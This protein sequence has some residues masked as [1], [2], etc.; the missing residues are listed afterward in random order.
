MI[1][2]GKKLLAYVLVLVMV[3]SLVPVTARAEEVVEPEV[4]E[5]H[6]TTET[7]G[8]GSIPYGAQAEL[9]SGIADVEIISYTWYQIVPDGEDELVGSDTS[10]YT[11]EEITTRTAYYC[12]MVD[13]DGAE[14]RIDFVVY[15]DSGLQAWV[16]GDEDHSDVGEISVKY[17]TPAE[18]TV[19]TSLSEEMS[20]QN[21]SYVWYKCVDDSDDVALD[22]SSASL[23][24]E[25]INYYTNYYCEVSDAYGN[26]VKVDFHISV[27]TGLYALTDEEEGSGSM[28]VFVIRGEDATLKVRAGLHYGPGEVHYEWLKVTGGSGDVISGANNASLELTNVTE[29]A[30]YHCKVSDDYGSHINVQ[31]DVYVDSGLE[32]CVA[33]GE[34]GEVY[35]YIYVPME[36]TTS[37]AVEASVADG[38]TLSYAWYDENPDDYSEG[39]E[40]YPTPLEDGNEDDTSYTTDAVTEQKVYYCKVRDEYGGSITLYFYVYIDSGLKAYV[41]DD[42]NQSDEAHINVVP[43]AAATLEVYATANEGET[44]TYEW[45]GETSG[46]SVLV[47]N[48]DETA[49]VYAKDGICTLKNINENAAYCCTVYD[50]YGN[51]KRIWFY[52]NVDTELTAYAKDDEFVRVPLNETATLEVEANVIEGVTLRYE[53]SYWNEDESVYEP[54][55]NVNGASCITKPITKREEYVCHV[56]DSCGNEA[57]VQ[58]YV[59]VDSNLNIEAVGDTTRTVSAGQT[60]QLAVKATADT[61]IT[62]QWNVFGSEGWEKVEGA[63]SDAY[64]VEDVKEATTYI[65]EVTDIYGDSVSQSFRIQVDN[66]LVATAKDNITEIKVDKNGSAILQ[67]EASAT[68]G[69]VTYQWMKNGQDINGAKTASYTVE[70]V[71]QY[72]TYICRVKDV[73]NNIK[74]VKFYVSINAD[75]GLTAVADSTCITEV[76][77]GK[78]TMLKVKAS[79]QSGTIIAYEWYEYDAEDQEWSFY[80]DGTNSIRTNAISSETLYKCVVR[81][82]YGNEVEVPFT[83][84]VASA[85]GE[86]NEGGTGGSTSEGNGNGNEGVNGGSTSE[87]TGDGNEGGTGGSTSEGTGNDGSNTTPDKENQTTTDDTQKDE[88]K[89]VT[90]LKLT[91]VSKKIAAGKKLTLKATFTPAD[92][93]NQKLTWSSSNKKYA[94]VNSKGVVT[95]KKAGAGKT[96]TITAEAQDGSGI[97][98]T[99]KITIMKH[100]VKSVKLT[101][102][103]KQVKVGKKLTLK[104]TVKTTGK[105]VNKTLEWSSSNTKYATVNSKGVVTAKKAG[106]G[107]KVKITA[108]ATDG[109]G[110]KATITIKIK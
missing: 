22:N 58:F 26:T 46:G 84:K 28:D 45:W 57:L 29:K 27:N 47:D 35:D 31:F 91:G 109:S 72:T 70:N 67:V 99:Y 63:T 90:K 86:G 34:P 85:G 95:T 41:K 1:T 24:T 18:L 98:A 66:G 50:D 69:D 61:E 94:T 92:V 33:G 20:N 56:T 42:P 71:S 101:A 80:E 62:Y 37:L 9:Y 48:S 93:T 6:G 52:V 21:L 107:K 15:V 19:A 102:K 65:C 68:T 100:A 77:A 110:K 55:E 16:F 30:T 89:L 75:D 25:N 3:I 36:Q 53:W 10:V 73:Y 11:T 32:A 64:T 23:Q 60:V 2:W 79:T 8:E 103:T 51:E 49:D 4:Y 39:D 13:E 76:E 78:K 59:F 97:K 106:K 81:D 104:A 88:P 12:Q 87:G 54:L 14:H 108:K 83:V 38:S 82:Q 5:I 17:N 40:N 43:G 105:K 96:V 44:I 7:T 74:T